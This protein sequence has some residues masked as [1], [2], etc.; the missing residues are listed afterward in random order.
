MVDLHSHIF[1][2][3]DDG[4]KSWEMTRNML[5]QA[6]DEGTTA[7]AWT[8]HLLSGEQIDYFA[9]IATR[10]T[11]GLAK[12]AEWK[13]PIRVFSGGE[14]YL[15]PDLERFLAYPCGSYGGLG[16]HILVEFP[17]YEYHGNYAE[18]IRRMTLKGFGIVLAHPER[19]VKLQDNEREYKRLADSGALLQI[20]AGSIRGDFGGETQKTAKTLIKSGLAKLAASDGHNDSSRPLG[21]AS[22]FRQVEKWTNRKRAEELFITAPAKILE[23][24]G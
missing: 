22:A 18:V 8:P 11:E 21:M 2:E 15:M 7:I 17:M 12:I 5:L 13:L 1:P 9:K 10:F 14:I 24:T 4:S 6:I 16:R 23:I 20:N 19:Y 3:I